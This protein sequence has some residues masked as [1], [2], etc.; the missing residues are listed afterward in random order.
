MKQNKLKIKSKMEEERRQRQASEERQRL[1]K[2][3]I[4][5][6]NQL[7]RSIN[8]EKTYKRHINEQQATQGHDVV[9]PPNIKIKWEGKSI[10]IANLSQSQKID[11]KKIKEITKI[12]RGNMVKNH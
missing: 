3:Q 9:P 2:E 12:Q 8:K 10:N 7:V 6:T 11:F 5:L 4:E 1:K